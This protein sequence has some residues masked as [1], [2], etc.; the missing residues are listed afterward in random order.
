MPKK[1]HPMISQILSE[2]QRLERQ[3]ERMELSSQVREFNQR[4]EGFGFNQRVE[5]LRRV[6]DNTKKHPEEMPFLKAL[7]ATGKWS[8]ELKSIGGGAERIKTMRINEPTRTPARA[9]VPRTEV[10]D[11]TISTREL[12]DQLKIPPRK[13]RQLLRREF[14]TKHERWRLTPQQVELI[15][16]KIGG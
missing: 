12:S 14:G 9:E 6:I 8:R 11:G 16:R 3:L 13:L 10:Q 4:W 1:Q 5:A 7:I 2:G 15:K